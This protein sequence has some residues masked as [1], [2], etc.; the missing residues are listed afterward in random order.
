MF[1]AEEVLHPAFI[2]RHA[3]RFGHGFQ[4]NIKWMN[5]SGWHS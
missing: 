5:L 3:R 2:T 1:T 4:P